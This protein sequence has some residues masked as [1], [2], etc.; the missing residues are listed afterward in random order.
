MSAKVISKEDFQNNVM[1]NQISKLVYDIKKRHTLVALESA[2][3]EK[4][5]DRLKGFSEEKFFR[6]ILKQEPEV[7]TAYEFTTPEGV[8]KNSFRFKSKPI[9][10]INKKPA[11]DVLKGVF[12][13]SAED[14]F[15]TVDEIEI[16]SDETEKFRQF[17][18]HPHLFSA[19]LRQDLSDDQLKLL[20]KGY[21]ELFNISVKAKEEYARLYPGSVKKT[22]EV[23]AQKGFLEAVAK[24]PADVKKKARKFLT[25]FL[26]PAVSSA[27]SCS[28]GKKK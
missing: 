23:H 26:K 2:E 4:D 13:S 22:V 21:P 15:K 14:L 9:V 17:G 20:V 27:V 12:G 10:E 6:D 1:Y 18:E 3:L 16:T 7:S 28:N 24:L 5:K 25:G 11:F 8:V 19:T